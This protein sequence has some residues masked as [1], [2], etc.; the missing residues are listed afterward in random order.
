MSTAAGSEQERRERCAGPAAGT[1][2]RGFTLLEAL[3]AMTLIMLVGMTL[4]GWISTNLLS[5]GRVQ[6]TAAR[7]QAEQSALAYLQTVNPMEHPQG[8][9]DLG[10]L[11][12]RWQARSIA[13]VLAG[14]G[15]A[16]G[17]S[18][19]TVGLYRVAVSL[20]TAA[21]Q[22]F[23]FTVRRAGFRSSGTKQGE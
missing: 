2:A 3:V 9:V 6:A 10:G 4:Y 21:G 22:S 1:A 19:Y 12:M 14:A 17:S 18:Q 7:A 11:R 5:L 16:G 13:P 15:Y 8:H 23:Q 20:R